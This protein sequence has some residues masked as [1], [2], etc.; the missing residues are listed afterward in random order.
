MHYLHKL[1]EAKK[2]NGGHDKNLVHVARGPASLP[3]YVTL[4]QKVEG[5][6]KSSKPGTMSMLLESF[7]L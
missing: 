4:V 2:H 5:L 3:N 7:V 6:L 1:Q